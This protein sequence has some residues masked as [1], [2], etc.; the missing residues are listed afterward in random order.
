MNRDRDHWVEKALYSKALLESIHYGASSPF[1]PIYGIEL[2]ASSI[3][4]GILYAL[5]NLSLNFSSYFG[6]CQS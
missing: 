5:S 2:G 1:I 4:V 3:E 6:V